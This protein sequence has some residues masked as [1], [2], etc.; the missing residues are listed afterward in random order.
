MLVSSLLTLVKEAQARHEGAIEM[1]KKEP[2]P[3]VTAQHDKLLWTLD[4][5]QGAFL[6]EQGLKDLLRQT[7]PPILFSQLLPHLPLCG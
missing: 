3:R 6:R 1:L 5:E 7:S 4:L 2:F